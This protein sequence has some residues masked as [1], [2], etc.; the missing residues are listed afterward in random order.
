MIQSSTKDLCKSGRTASVDSM[1][2]AAYKESIG[3]P[4]VS[5]VLPTY[6]GS[7]Y[8]AEAI[9]SCVNQTYP[10]WELIIVDDGSTDETPEIVAKYVVKDGR[11]K[12]IRHDENRNLPAALNTGF[13]VARGDLFTW[14][15]DDNQ[16]R[17]EALR[18]MVDFLNRNPSVDV[19][20][21]DRSLIDEYG[22][23][24][25]VL[26]AASPDELP[27]INSVGACFLYRKTLHES[28]GAYTEHFYMA[29]DHEFWLRA[30]GSFTFH[31]LH[32]DLYLYRIHDGSLTESYVESTKLAS[33][34]VLEKYLDQYDWQGQVRG[35]VLLTLAEGAALMKDLRAA[36]SYL[37]KAFRAW[38]FVICK[39]QTLIVLIRIIAG[40]KGF[41]TF[42]RFYKKVKVHTSHQL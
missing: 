8:L 34:R 38:P 3:C 30:L 17:P 14:T 40:S 15:S 33:R 28:L 26:I 39:K 10:N 35:K 20:Y 41:D 5:I 37:V 18:V 22:K 36:R 24:T 2:P 9:E 32:K 23:V 21:T 42:Y 7:R 25:G 31:C 19:V 27:Y 11:I 6:N 16:Y 13:A 1:E 4:F 29:E 12:S